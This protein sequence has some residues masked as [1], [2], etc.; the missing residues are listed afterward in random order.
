MSG[1][2]GCHSVCVAHVASCAAHWTHTHVAYEYVCKWVYVQAARQNREEIARLMEEN[3]VLHAR[4]ADARSRQ[5]QESAA[6]VVAAV[7]LDQARMLS[8]MVMAA[9]A[10]P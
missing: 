8:F 4:L 7:R 9:L 2:K 1:H 6:G 10:P 3:S 5:M